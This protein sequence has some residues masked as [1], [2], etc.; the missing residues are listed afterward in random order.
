[1]KQIRVDFNYADDCMDDLIRRGNSIIDFCEDNHNLKS[2]KDNNMLYSKMN[3][4]MSEFYDAQ[5]LIIE[6]LNHEARLVKDVARQYQSM[7]RGLKEGAD[8]L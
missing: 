1:M 8:K 7:D 6:K 4:I 5:K 3:S 2:E